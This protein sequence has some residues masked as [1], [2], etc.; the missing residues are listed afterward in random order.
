M[1]VL[2]SPPRRKGDRR[3]ASTSAQRTTALLALF[4]A[5]LVPV[6]IVA[7]QATAAEAASEAPVTR[8]LRHST[9]DL[10]DM[11][12]PPTRPAPFGS[13]DAIATLE[14][15]DYALSEVADGATYVW[16][17]A[18]GRLSGFMTPLNTFRASGGEVCR[19]M[20]IEIIADTA[21]RRQ[22]GSAC[23]IADGTWRLGL[24]AHPALRLSQ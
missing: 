22:T 4:G 19:T 5:L 24:E 11:A 14:A 15:F 9:P 6:P 21:T 2:L 7:A 10:K 1:L 23:R 20:R 17:R 18:H 13:A 3:R 8:A 12:R 16:H